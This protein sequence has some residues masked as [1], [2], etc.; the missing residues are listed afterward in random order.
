MQQEADALNAMYDDVQNPETWKRIHFGWPVGSEN[1]P[2]NEE[3][4]SW[5]LY[6]SDLRISEQPA[7]ASGWRL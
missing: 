2:T 7:L 1:A 4:P 5:S 3:K 6:W